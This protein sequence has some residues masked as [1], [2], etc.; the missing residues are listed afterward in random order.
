M[1]DRSI[2]TYYQIQLAASSKQKPARVSPSNI[3]QNGKSTAVRGVSKFGE[4]SD[5]VRAGS[6]NYMHGLCYRLRLK[7]MD[8][9]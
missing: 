8:K 7:G 2:G 5:L 1:Y 6:L 9:R 3:L 4:T